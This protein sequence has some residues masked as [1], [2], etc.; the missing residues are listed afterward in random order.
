[1]GVETRFGEVERRERDRL[2]SR[3]SLDEQEAQYPLSGI[4]VEQVFD[5]NRM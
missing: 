3:T 2:R 1:M 5:E 4:D